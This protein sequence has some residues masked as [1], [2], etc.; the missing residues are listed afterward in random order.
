MRGQVGRKD[1][2]GHLHPHQAPRK[3]K[4]RFTFTIHPVAMLSDGVRMSHGIA[5]LDVSPD[6]GHDAAAMHINGTP[7]ARSLT[8][9]HCRALQSG[10]TPL[11]THKGTFAGLAGCN[12]LDVERVV[13]FAWTWR[14][15]VVAHHCCEPGDAPH[16]T[17]RLLVLGVGLAEKTMNA[18]LCA[19]SECSPHGTSLCQPH[20]HARGQTP[21]TSRRC[22]AALQPAD[23]SDGLQGTAVII[24]TRTAS[25][26]TA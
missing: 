11:F 6:L 19:H 7:H 15:G 23:Q 14:I 5:R 21:Y 13:D 3:A 2:I 24:M 1:A 25:S 17:C 10:S 18:R 20:L 26:R 16:F 4:I 9:S 8:S 12:L 22:K